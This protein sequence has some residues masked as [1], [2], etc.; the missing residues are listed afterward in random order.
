MTVIE[1]KLLRRSVGWRLTAHARAVATNRG[2]AIPEVLAA[3]VEPEIRTTAFDYGDGRYRH[4]RGRLVVIIVPESQ[5][6]VTVLLRSTSVWTDEDA[7][8]AVA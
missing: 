5:V 4:A 6:V 3:C 7:R 8:R 2:F 1:P